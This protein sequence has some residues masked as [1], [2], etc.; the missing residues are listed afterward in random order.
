MGVLCGL[1]AWAGGTD[2]DRVGTRL[3]SKQSTLGTCSSGDE[4]RPGARSPCQGRELPWPSGWRG[5]FPG[6]GIN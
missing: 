3:R 4:G 5:F 2:V 1:A 6:V